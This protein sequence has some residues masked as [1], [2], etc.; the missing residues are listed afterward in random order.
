MFYPDSMLIMFEIKLNGL[1]NS[2]AKVT[3]SYHTHLILITGVFKKKLLQQQTGRNFFMR[4]KST[5]TSRGRTV[6]I[7]SATWKVQCTLYDF[8]TLYL[9]HAHTFYKPKGQ[10]SSTI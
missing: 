3:F 5:L 8:I 4:L 1:M 10:Y 9:T 7:K 2:I 6:N